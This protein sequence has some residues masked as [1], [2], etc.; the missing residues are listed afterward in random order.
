MVII[1]IWILLSLVVA[2]FG[3]GRKIGF[4]KSLF[5][6]VFLTPVIGII[7]ISFSQKK[8]DIAQKKET[9]KLSKEYLDLINPKK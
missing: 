8:K 9:E 3:A 6:S 1:I 7:I 4:I 2:I 5:T